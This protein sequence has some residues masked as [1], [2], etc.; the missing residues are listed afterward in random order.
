[1]MKRL[2]A[3][4]AVATLLAAPTAAQQPLTMP[5]TGTLVLMTGTAEVEIPNDEAVADFYFEVQDAD[6]TRAQALVNQRLTE[7]TAAVKRADPK[8][9]L[10]S[11]GYSSYP[12]YAKNSDAII[13]WRV[14]QGVTLRTENLAALPKTVASA[15]PS[16]AL[17]RIDFGLTKPT[18]EKIEAQLIQLAMSNLRSRLAA[19]AQSMNVPANRLRLE[20]VDF[21]ERQTAPPRPMVMRSMATAEQTTPPTF[22]SGRSIER[23][24][25]SGKA[26]LLP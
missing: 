7:G 19:A 24:M 20:E 12:V 14:R 26:R 10:E 18:R 3:A 4:T 13:G 11:S 17:G 16:L 23:L 21:S 6:L 8:A 2:L 25:V 5:P 22:E 1:M 15:Q 9:K